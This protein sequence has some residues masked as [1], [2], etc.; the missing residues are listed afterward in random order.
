MKPTQSDVDSENAT[1]DHQTWLSSSPHPETWLIV[2]VGDVS[3]DRFAT[4]EIVQ[5]EAARESEALREG[6]ERV[7]V[8]EEG[9]NSATFVVALFVVTVR[10]GESRF[11]FRLPDL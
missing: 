9:T 7:L 6:H 2:V 3:G 8:A 10:E 1:R 11:Q 4:V 5:S